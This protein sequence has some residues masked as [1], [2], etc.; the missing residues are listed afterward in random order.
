MNSRAV[1]VALSSD[2]QGVVRRIDL[3]GVQAFAAASENRAPWLD[4]LLVVIDG[5]LVFERYLHGVRAQESSNIYSITKCWLSCLVGIALEKGLLGSLDTPLAEIFVDRIPAGSDH[6]KDEIT[7][8]HCPAMQ[9]GLAYENTFE[10]ETEF[11][12]AADPVA[13]FFSDRLPVRGPPGETWL[14]SGADSQMVAE[15]LRA[16]VGRSLSDIAREWLAEPLGV[17]DF[18]WARKFPTLG[19]ATWPA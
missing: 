1:E 9:S 18:S 8:R 2:P 6:R 10:F 11:G 16:R 14:Y 5:E 17:D 19:A 15:A 12:I 4:S 13:F 3:R 7:I